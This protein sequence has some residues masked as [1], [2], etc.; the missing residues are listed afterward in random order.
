[1]SLASTAAWLVSYWLTGEY[2]TKPAILFWN[3]LVELGFFLVVT[4]ALARVRA[5][6]ATEHSLRQ[7]LEVAYRQLDDQF[8]VVGDIQRRLLPPRVP[9]LPGYRIAVHYAASMRAGGDYYDFFPLPDGR[10]G[11]MIADVSGHGPAAA[12]VMAMTRVLLHRAPEA[13]TLPERALEALNAQLEQSVLRGQFVTACYSTLEPR[14]GRVA[15]ALAGHDPPLLVRGG[16]GALEAFENPGGLPLGVFEAPRFTRGE[17]RLGPGDALLYYT[18]GL[19]EASDAEGHM[20]GVERVH[21]LLRASRGLEPEAIRDRLLE[22]L[23]AH[24]GSAAPTDDLTLI[25]VRA[26]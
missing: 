16:S 9:D 5:G 8:R 15:Y 12:V 22:G 23:R 3:T 1:M 4:F 2:F 6:L 11:L 19:T 24:V 25:V 10:L 14:S 20:F 17:V 7:Q 18:D 21:E 26:V 13:L